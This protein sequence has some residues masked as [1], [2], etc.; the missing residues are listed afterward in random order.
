MPCSLLIWDNE[1]F[2]SLWICDKEMSLF[3]EYKI[4]KC[5][6]LYKYDIMKH[7]LWIRDDKMSCS[8]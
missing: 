2:F 7:S 8:L 5:P 4:I 1:T 3:Y 6:V